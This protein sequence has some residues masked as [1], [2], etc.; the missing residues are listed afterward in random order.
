MGEAGVVGVLAMIAA[1][2]GLL[3]GEAAGWEPWTLDVLWGSLFF[4]SC[5]ALVIYIHRP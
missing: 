4:H 3:C 2:K 5:S 1:C